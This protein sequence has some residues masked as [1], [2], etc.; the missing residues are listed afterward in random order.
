MLN[1]SANYF[2]ELKNQKSLNLAKSALHY[3]IELEDDELIAKSY[4]MIGLNFEEYSDSNKA[5]EY[6]EKGIKH[7]NLT[8]NDSVKQWLYNNIGNV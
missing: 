7:A 4:N 3:S 8:K 1:Q 6:Y 5:I 2:D